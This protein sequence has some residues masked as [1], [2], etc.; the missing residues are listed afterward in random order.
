[1]GYNIG[2]E[3]NALTHYT[4]TVSV[5]EDEKILTVIQAQLR[6]KQMLWFPRDDY[7]QEF[8]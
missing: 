6:F 5:L 3:S 2:I 7:F 1:M 8:S 4:D